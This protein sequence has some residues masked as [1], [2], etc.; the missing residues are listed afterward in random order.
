MRHSPELV[1]V[2]HEVVWFMEPDDALADV[3]FFLA[4]VMTYATIEEI[5]LVEKYFTPADFRRALENAP[6]GVFDQRSWAYW[7]TVFD[8]V[9]VPPMPKRRLGEAA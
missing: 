5:A 2:A 8:R 1:N 4:H 3:N 9:P 7:H 6:A